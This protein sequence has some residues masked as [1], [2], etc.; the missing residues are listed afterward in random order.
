MLIKRARRRP[1][2]PP[3]IFLWVQGYHHWI[4]ER[5]VRR[6]M[7]DLPRFPDLDQQTLRTLEAQPAPES[8]PVPAA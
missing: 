1:S 7:I 3:Y 6:D 2:Q 4:T 8:Q 5:L